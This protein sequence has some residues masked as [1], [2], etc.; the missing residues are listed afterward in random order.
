MEM[1][2]GSQVRPPFFPALLISFLGPAEEFLAHEHAIQA[3]YAKSR[4]QRF[5]EFISTLQQENIVLQ[6]C[7]KEET[8]RHDELNTQITQAEVINRSLE[9]KIAG[10]NQQCQQ[11][12]SQ[13]NKEKELRE[14]AELKLSTVERNA[15]TKS[16]EAERRL[17]DALQIHERDLEQAKKAYEDSERR[18]REELEVCNREKE[19]VLEVFRTVTSIANASS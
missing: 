11:T 18:L 15:E 7:V 17:A 13:L 16:V 5:L 9:L 8:A 3:A 14:E 4:D 2:L 12:L 10:L 1:Q 6:R 19:R